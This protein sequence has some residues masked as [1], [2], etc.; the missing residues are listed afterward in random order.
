M[1]FASVRT[2]WVSTF[3]RTSWVLHIVR[4]TVPSLLLGLLG[5]LQMLGRL[6]F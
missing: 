1:D 3:L 2:S 4:I 5:L 6:G